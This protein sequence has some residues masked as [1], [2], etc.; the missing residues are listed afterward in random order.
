MERKN[1]TLQCCKLK[2]W[3]LAKLHVQQVINKVMDFNIPEDENNKFH[4]N[5]CEPHMSYI[6]TRDE[7]VFMKSCLEIK[8]FS[9]ALLSQ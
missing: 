3:Q 9:D 8:N 7:I 2:R 6:I 4:K 5:K 1:F